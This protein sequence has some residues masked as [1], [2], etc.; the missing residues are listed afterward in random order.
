MGVYAIFRH[1][2]MQQ[3]ASTEAIEKQNWETEK[4][5][6]PTK[7]RDLSM[8]FCVVPVEIVAGFQ[9]EPL[10]KLCW[11]QLNGLVQS[12]KKKQLKAA[13]NSPFKILPLC[14]VDIVDRWIDSDCLRVGES[15]TTS[16]KQ[17]CKLYNIHYIAQYFSK[18]EGVGI[19]N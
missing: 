11:S 12:P 16:S 7:L 9:T 18:V 17:A 10:A 5:L 4:L 19:W 6:G 2:Q 15:E 13:I 1:T 14:I 8:K 3:I